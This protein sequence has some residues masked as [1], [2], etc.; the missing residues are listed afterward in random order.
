M[1]WMGGSVV[2]AG[3][4]DRSR[5]LFMAAGLSLIVAVA[6]VRFP[7]PILAL[8]LA[9][10]A[11]LGAAF[12]PTFLALGYL[13]VLPLL[14][15]F[16]TQLP[17]IGGEGGMS[18]N[19]MGA[20]N[21]F[22]IGAGSLAIWR[23]WQRVAWK[24][25]WPVY[26]LTVYL[27]ATVW[28]SPEPLLSLRNWVAYAVPSTL[29]LLLSMQCR[30]GNPCGKALLALAVCATVSGV[31]GGVQLA[32]WDLKFHFNGIPRI[33]GG[34]GHPNMFA[35]F[36]VICILAV[37]LIVTRPLTGGTKMLLLGILALLSFQLFFTFSRSGWIVL[38][39]TLLAGSLLL[40]RFA[41]GIL[42]LTVLS[43]GFFI[44][45]LLPLMME[46][47]QPDSAFYMRFTLI[48]LGWSHFLEAPFFGHGVG[49]FPLLSRYPLG[50]VVERYDI[51]MGLTPHNDT[52]R[53]LVEAGVAGFFLYIALLSQVVRVGLGLFRAGSEPGKSLGVFLVALAAGT[54]VFGLGG[55]GFSYAGPYLLAATGIAAVYSRDGATVRDGSASN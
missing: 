49:S 18:L 29:A 16:G 5:P 13:A 22:L 8:I 31:L 50:A 35:M 6:F 33:W 24:M 15:T 30:D 1:I 36:L 45:E 28:I 2:R 52:I 21:L 7:V 9:G 25:L 51:R 14:L 3:I 48:R 47:F 20:A 27:L 17:V 42:I 44:T 40:K 34:H 46:R 23:G 4:L 19:L 38:G 11:A 55:Q 37:L 39:I 12:R 41:V 54:V 32:M 26:A 10:L 53:F 43:A